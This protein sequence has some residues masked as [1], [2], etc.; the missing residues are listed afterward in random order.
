MRLPPTRSY[1]L[2]RWPLTAYGEAHQEDTFVG[3]GVLIDF[4]I[5]HRR[6]FAFEELGRDDARACKH[7][8]YNHTAA[9]KNMSKFAKCPAVSDL[10]KRGLLLEDQRGAR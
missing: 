7:R 8:G 6:H 10:K 4:F 2:R 1:R 9:A 3:Q 5:A